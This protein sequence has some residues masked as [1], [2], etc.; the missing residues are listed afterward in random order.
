[1]AFHEPS[2]WGVYWARDG[3]KMNAKGKSMQHCGFNE[4]L[5]FAVVVVVVAAV[6]AAAAAVVVVVVLLIV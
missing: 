2:G 6:A 1:M 4:M 3:T 5:F